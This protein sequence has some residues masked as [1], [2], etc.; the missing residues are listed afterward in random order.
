MEALRSSETLVLKRVT[1][2]NI[3]EDGILHSHRREN[4]KSYKTKVAP[5]KKSI[6]GTS[7]VTA[8]AKQLVHIYLSSFW[9]YIIQEP[10]NIH[11]L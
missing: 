3:P 11:E 2:C 1:G 4:H 5:Q 8:V 10:L 7:Q 6:K 9:K